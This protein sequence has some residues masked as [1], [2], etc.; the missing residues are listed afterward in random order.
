M[1]I[2]I[3]W[4]L[5]NEDNFER[6]MSLQNFL[7][8]PTTQCAFVRILLHNARPILLEDVSD[9]IYALKIGC[10]RKYGKNMGKKNGC[11]I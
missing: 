7:D 4:R 1:L 6:A 9:E 8:I 3:G 2:A 5:V 10:C 11:V